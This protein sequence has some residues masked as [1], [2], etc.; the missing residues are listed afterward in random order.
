MMD[1]DFEGISFKAVQMR[2][3]KELERRRRGRR[4][5]GVIWET[6]RRKM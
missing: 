2:W 6:D 3:H 4:R 1:A 5:K